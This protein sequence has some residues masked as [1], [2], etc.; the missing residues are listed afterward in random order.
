MIGPPVLPDHALIFVTV[1]VSPLADWTWWHPLLKCATD[2]GVL[3]VFFALL[4][5]ATGWRWSALP[6]HC[7]MDLLGGDLGSPA[8][9]SEAK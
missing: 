9:P 8:D 5:L 1:I 2:A 7:A 3:G 6:I 4:V